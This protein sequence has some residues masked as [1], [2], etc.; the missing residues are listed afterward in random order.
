[1]QIVCKA[2]L[3]QPYELGSDKLG[4]R[5]GFRHGTSHV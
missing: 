1:M 5:P 2:F 3:L 4:A